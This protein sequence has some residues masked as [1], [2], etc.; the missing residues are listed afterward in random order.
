MLIALLTAHPANNSHRRQPT[1]SVKAL[2]RFERTLGFTKGK[3]TWSCRRFYRLI[4]LS[5]INVNVYTLT[6]ETLRT[7]STSSTSNY[8][9]QQVSKQPV[10]PVT[11]HVQQYRAYFRIDKVRHTALSKLTDYCVLTVLYPTFLQHKS[12]QTFS[13]VRFDGNVRKGGKTKVK[14]W[15]PVGER[16]RLTHSQRHSRGC[17]LMIAPKSQFKFTILYDATLA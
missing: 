5:H 6:N 12:F 3:H 14:P 11:S 16:G 13:C 2:K 7:S 4:L 1:P 15:P 10:I 17:Q 8:L 9:K